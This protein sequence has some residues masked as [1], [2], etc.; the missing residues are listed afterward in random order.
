MHV[1]SR[2]GDW[3]MKNNCFVDGFL[4]G[5]LPIHSRLGLTTQQPVKKKR[6]RSKRGGSGSGS[7][8]GSGGTL[9]Q[10]LCFIGSL[11][12]IYSCCYFK[13]L[14]LLFC[15]RV[16]VCVCVCCKQPKLLLYLQIS[17]KY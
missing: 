5:K 16:C 15:C 14:F 1:L 2:G 7:G 3:E 9:D 10:V 6:K 13:R 12:I 4:D 17:F 11:F 8:G